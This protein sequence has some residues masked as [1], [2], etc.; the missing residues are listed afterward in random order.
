HKNTAP[1][2]DQTMSNKR[3]DKDKIS[4]ANNAAVMQV[5]VRLNEHEQEILQILNFFKDISVE[6][7]FRRE[8]IIIT[9]TEKNIKEA[10]KKISEKILKFEKTVL[11][12]T[13]IHITSLD[14]L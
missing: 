7:D 13:H 11:N 12:V 14:L 1:E 9:G 2:I 8:N 3:T 5:S 6:K 10:K 4:N